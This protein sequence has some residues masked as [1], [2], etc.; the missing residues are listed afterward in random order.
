M[1]LFH[2]APW[3]SATVSVNVTV[4]TVASVQRDFDTARGAVHDTRHTVDKLRRTETQRGS[5]QSLSAQHGTCQHSR[6]SRESRHSTC[7]AVSVKT[8][9][10]TRPVLSPVPLGTF[11]CLRLVVVL[12]SALTRSSCPVRVFSSV[13]TAGT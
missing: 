8:H 7:A 3:R 11:W 13:G 9:V 4:P 6:E 5:R 10:P 1:A 12:V 2:T